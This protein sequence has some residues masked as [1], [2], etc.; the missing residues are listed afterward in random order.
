VLLV[1]PGNDD[2]VLLQWLDMLSQVEPGRVQVL[3][4]MPGQPREAMRNAAA[5]EAQGEFLLWLDATAMVSD[6]DWLPALLNHAQRPEVGAVGCM[7]ASADGVI[8]QAGLVL[9]L[10]GSVGPAFAG[11]VLGDEGALSALVTERNGVAVGDRCLMVRRETFLQSGGFSVDPLLAP[12]A[13]ADLCLRLQQAGYLNVWTPRARLLLEAAPAAAISAEQE[14][15]LYARWLPQ[16]VSDPS[17][18]AN[19]SLL[20]GHSHARQDNGLCWRPLQGIAPTVLA[21]AADQQAA[22]QA[23]VIQPLMAMRNAGLIDGSVTMGVLTLVSDPGGYPALCAL[24]YCLAAPAGGCGVADLASSARI[25]PGIQ[26][27]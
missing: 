9:G 25:L 24:E 4:F 19:Q 5:Q 22:G 1:E 17:Y 13:E 26:G 18:N 6:G 12:W 15:A 2:P 8:Q 21:F 27:V 20:A 7:L 23:R 3:R 16:L 14:D 11:H 10:G